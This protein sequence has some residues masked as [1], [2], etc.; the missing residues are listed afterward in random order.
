MWPLTSKA[1]QALV[2]SH[3]MTVR[4]TAYGSFGTLEI[5]ISGGEVTSDAK[6]QTRRTASTSTNLSLW[7]RDPRGV[8]APTGTEIQI[9]YGI[10]LPGGTTEWIPLI[11]GLLTE[12][13]RQRPI[14]TSGSF[15]LKLMD[16]SKRVAEDR[17]PAPV[18][19][20]A[21]ALTVVEIRR[22]I[23]ET[24]GVSVPVVDRSGSAHVAPVLDIERERWADGVE[25]LADSIAAE[26]FFDPQGNGVIRAQPQITDPYV[27]RIASGP[28]GT[29]LSKD[30]S[31]SRE[32]I[33]NGVVVSG[34][35]VDGTLAV[36]A[37]VWDT[38]PASP[39]YYL[40]AFGKKPRFYSSP[41]LTTVPQC[42]AAGAA[43]LA[44]VR[45]L[46]SKVRFTAIVN[47]ALEAGDVVLLDDVDDG[48]S[49]LHIIDAVTVPLS[50]AEA[51]PME[52][53]S[54]DVPTES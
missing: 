39:T 30:D 12:A 32:G 52:T 28:G 10:L 51:Q 35:R 21:G 16:R 25:K 42:Q 45:G 18:Q 43:L 24:L 22:L 6:S 20:V 41:Q 33:Y 17:F 48:V 29:L 50:P 46:N 23:Q 26:V 13:S 36:M 1:A 54:L 11:R 19:T 49:E 3:G 7:P 4:A 44:R 34:E 2:Q 31:L 37:T 38:D 14:P 47:P 40:G 27:W 9:D 15:P 53:R 8:L 5:P